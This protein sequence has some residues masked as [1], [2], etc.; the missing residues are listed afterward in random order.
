MKNL[1]YLLLLLYLVFAG[2]DR[3]NFGGN[4]ID[5]F[6]L[7]PHIIISILILSF[8]F[9]FKFNDIN[10]YWIYDKK[11][12][13]FSFLLFFVFLI[14][15][16]IFSIDISYSFKRFILLLLIITTAIFILSSY[17]NKELY[18]NFY[19]ASI[20]G[21]LLF[22][23]FN[24]LLFMNWIGYI[25][26]D[27]NILNLNPDYIAYFLPRLGGFSADVNRGIVILII[28]T[29]FL[30]SYKSNN[31]KNIFINL[32]II[33]NTIF[34]FASLSRTAIGFFI[35]TFFLYSIFLATRNERKLAILFIPISLLLL[36]N[37]VSFYS[38]NDIIDVE[39]ALEERLNMN[40]F[41]HNTSAGI[42]MKLINEGFKVGFSNPKIFTIGA[43]H[44]VSN[45]LIK[46][47]E[48]SRKKTANFH[49]Q[50]LSIFVEN[51]FFATIFLLL[52][53]ILLPLFYYHNKILPLIIGLFCFNLL[54]QLTNEP[55]YWFTLL[56][57]YKFNDYA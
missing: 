7:F 43:G 39:S 35:I 37:I 17:S 46:G 49:S 16:I 40:D 50:Y 20:L 57:Y 19:Y 14:I 42:H 51:G 24:I 6:Q 21:S 26:I 56:Y 8:I 31:K 1:S 28:Y 34:I 11:Y 13:L 5:S 38:E 2:V 36:Y 12:A 30:F 15:S 10:F 9:L 54:Y 27:S 4:S 47:F 44:G 3:I 41:G 25:N 48:M 29:F 18:Q 22:C 45:K 55:L 52:F 23:I 53:T 32:L 33:L